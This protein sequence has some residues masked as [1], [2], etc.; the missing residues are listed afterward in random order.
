MN[1]GFGCNLDC[2]QWEA[3]VFVMLQPRCEFVGCIET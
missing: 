1:G 3:F 2:V